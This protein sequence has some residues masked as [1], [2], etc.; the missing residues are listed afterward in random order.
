MRVRFVGIR[1]LFEGFIFEILEFE[2]ESGEMM[3]FF[4][5]SGCGKMIIL[6]IIVG[7]EKF[8]FGRVFFDEIDVMNLE[9]GKRNIGIVF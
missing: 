3:M 7:F 8:D 4:G 2:V 5:L 1:K 9:L 6:W